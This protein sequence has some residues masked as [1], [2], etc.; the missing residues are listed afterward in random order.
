MAASTAGVNRVW[1]SLD[2]GSQGFG[3]KLSFFIGGDTVPDVIAGMGDL[4]GSEATDNAVSRFLQVAMMEN[5]E[6]EAT[7]A[8]REGGMVGNDQGSPPNA[9][10]CNHG[11]MV[12]KE[13][14][15]AKG[16]W[17]AWFCPTPK[18]TPGQCKA[19]FL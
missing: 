13:G 16:A 10:V 7:G 8:L 1:F 19:R 18:G 15:S 12:Y 9:P 11:A 17:K 3:P 2:T 14:Q 6:A 5:V 4:L